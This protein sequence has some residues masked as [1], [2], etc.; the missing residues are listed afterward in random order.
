VAAARCLLV[1]ET[2]WTRSVQS[3]ALNPEGNLVAVSD[4]ED[5]FEIWDLQTNRLV[6]QMDRKSSPLIDPISFSPDGKIVA[7]GDRHGGVTLMDPRGREIRRLDGCRRSD[8][9]VGIGRD[10]NTVVAA[11]DWRKCAIW[12]A[13]NMRRISEFEAFGFEAARFSP[14]CDFV[15]LKNCNNF[16]TSLF[17]MDGRKTADFEVARI[18]DI[19]FSRDGELIA[20]LNG[21]LDGSVE[22]IR[23]RTGQRVRR[24]QAAESEIQSAVLHPDG[25]LLATGCADGVIRFWD[26]ETGLQRFELADPDTLDFQPAC[27]DFDPDGRWLVAG[28][29]AGYLYLWDFT[30]RR[31]LRR[32]G[33]ASGAVTQVRFSPDSRM[34][35]SHN[36]EAKSIQLWNASLCNRIHTITGRSTPTYFE[37]TRDSLALSIT[38]RFYQEGSTVSLVSL[39][40]GEE[41]VSLRCFAD[42]TWIACDHQGHYASSQFSPHQIG[43]RVGEDVY[44]NLDLHGDYRRQALL[45]QAP[46]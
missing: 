45:E 14:H 11:G 3:A 6:Y 26:P 2:G 37:F 28:T 27:L 15:V 20:A 1:V 42:D 44:Q 43:W 5:G 4:S 32:F 40:T 18:G 30:A 19:S 12:D 46:L 17:G 9:A 36:G 41:I 13:K 38:W 39:D 22:I 34:V 33:E 10:R 24:I 8:T 31:L 7:C 35:A 25:R 21:S 29:N 23:T 16:N